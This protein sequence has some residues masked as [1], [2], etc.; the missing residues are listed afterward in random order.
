MHLNTLEINKQLEKTRYKS[1]YNA[2]TMA[3]MTISH[4]VEEIL[5]P[6]PLAHDYGSGDD[7]L[8]RSWGPALSW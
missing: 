2:T 7:S 8:P 5:T 4:C 6:P 1:Y 3:Y